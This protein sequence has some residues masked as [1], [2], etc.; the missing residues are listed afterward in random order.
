MGAV[1][2]HHVLCVHVPLDRVVYACSCTCAVFLVCSDS[3]MCVIDQLFS[4][5]MPRLLGW[6]QVL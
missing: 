1:Q 6:D 2:P 3:E 4:Y 5:S